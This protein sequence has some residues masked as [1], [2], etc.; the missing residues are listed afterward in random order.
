MRQKC[1]L[2]AEAAELFAQVMAARK[3]ALGGGAA[4]AEKGPAQ[5]MEPEEEDPAY[6][7]PE[8]YDLERSISMT[9][10]IASPEIRPVHRTLTNMSRVSRS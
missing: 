7:N 1:K 8:I 9:E 10:E 3:A 4:D 5:A 2:A 6:G